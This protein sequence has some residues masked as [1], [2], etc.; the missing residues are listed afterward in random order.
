MRRAG[1][2]GSRAAPI[3]GAWG[4]R[5]VIDISGLA[6][7]VRPKLRTSPSPNVAVRSEH[8]TEAGDGW[9]PGWLVPSLFATSATITITDSP[10]PSGL[11]GQVLEARRYLRRLPDRTLVY[12]DQY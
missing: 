1:R 2:P 3:R 6:R 9:C 7:S 12:A 11:R 8:H 5:Q 10:R 4:Q